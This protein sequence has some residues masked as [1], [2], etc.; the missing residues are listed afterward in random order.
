[1][2]RDAARCGGHSQR[3]MVPS[4]QSSLTDSEL[5]SSVR[6]MSVD[7][8]VSVSPAQEAGA[9]SGR[10]KQ[11]TLQESSA[12]V[13]SG[14]AARSKQGGHSLLAGEPSPGSGDDFQHVSKGHTRPKAQRQLLD[15]IDEGAAGS[16][17]DAPKRRASEGPRPP[18][19]KGPV[20]RKPAPGTMLAVSVTDEM[21]QDVYGMAE[22]LQ[23]EFQVGARTHTH[24]RTFC[25]LHARISCLARC[26]WGI[27]G[28]LM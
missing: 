24:A 2:A 5:G 25:L 11:G 15:S 16:S 14:S 18:A 7:T 10:G 8:N 26:V 13:L 12:A 1:M 3:G 20:P 4:M 28:L 22:S 9:K 17:K 27:F 19:K 21:T 23:M 6:G